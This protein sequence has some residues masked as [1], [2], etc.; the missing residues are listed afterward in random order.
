[1]INVYKKNP[2]VGRV[3]RIPIQVLDCSGDT[4]S[5]TS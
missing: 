5:K 1:M 2:D 4:F 3:E